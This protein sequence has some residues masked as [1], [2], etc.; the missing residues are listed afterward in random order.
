M[1]FV[2]SG[3]EQIRAH[4]RSMPQFCRADFGIFV[5]IWWICVTW[6]STFLSVSLVFF[7][8]L[9]TIFVVHSPEQCARGQFQF[10]CPFPLLLPFLRYT[11]FPLHLAA[12]RRSRHRVAVSS[13]VV[14]SIES[15]SFHNLHWDT[16]NQFCL[17]SPRRGN[18]DAV[19]WSI[20]RFSRIQSSLRISC[21]ATDILIGFAN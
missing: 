4:L 7:L 21:R 1:A 13:C 6:I 17:C 8:H 12:S 5:W 9:S 11:Q 3:Y 19:P 20:D 10:G 18:L 2:L 14:H 16:T 15:R